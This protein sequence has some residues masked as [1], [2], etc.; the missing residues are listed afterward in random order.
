MAVLINEEKMA[1]SNVFKYEER[2][3]SPSSRFIDST[4]NYVDYYHIN[5]NETTSDGGFLDVSAIIGKDSPI[6]YQKIEHFPLYNIDA[7][8]LQ[9]QDDASIGLDAE[10][11]SDAVILPGTIKPLPNDFFIIPYLK[12]SYVFRVTEITYDN[13]MPDNFYKLS[14]KLEFIDK[15]KTMELEDQ[16]IEKF[17]CK[18][19][20]IGTDQK[21]I[22]EAKDMETLNKIDDMYN[23]IASTYV[24]VFFN[25]RYNCVLGDIIPGKVLYDPLMTEFMNKHSL[26]NRKNQMDVK[27]LSDHYV[28][29]KRRIKY[30]KSVWRFLERRDYRLMSNFYFTYFGAGNLPDSIFARYYDSTVQVLDIPSDLNVNNMV[31]MPIFTDEFV[32][33][34]KLNGFTHSEHADLI[35]KFVRNEE[36]KLSDIPLDLNEE[37]LK[38]DANLEVF[39]VTPMILYIIKTVVEDFM[40]KE[41]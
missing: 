9:L 10:F 4:P 7:I 1:E 17:T 24:S 35:Q 27:I 18:F 26:L 29:N 3:K 23:D 39:F 11:E 2:L 16:V 38:L 6:K 32:N 12:D 37:L 28:D 31:V 5:N 30:E 22:I 13:I 20:N 40:T 41:K 21:C 8:I 15:D 34:V 36:I 19:E 25:D 14:Y 33:S